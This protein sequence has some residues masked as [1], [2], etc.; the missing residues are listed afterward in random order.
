MY[1]FLK[2]ETINGEGLPVLIAENGM[3]H[4]VFRGRVEQRGDTATCDVF[5]QAFIFEALRAKKD[6]VPLIGYLYWSMVDNY[7][8]GSYDPRFGLYAVDRSRVPAKISS[9]DSWGTDAAQ[10]YRDIIAALRGGDREEIVEAFT[11]ND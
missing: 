6:G 11:R 3:S 9:V 1:H 2:A 10:A 4:K 7:E 8:W 5:L